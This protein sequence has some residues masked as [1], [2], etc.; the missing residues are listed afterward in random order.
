MYS[1]EQLFVGV[2][3][4]NNRYLAAELRTK[5][6]NKDRHVGSLLEQLRTGRVERGVGNV[7][8]NTLPVDLH[9]PVPDLVVR[10][11]YDRK[12]PHASEEREAGEGEPSSS[13]SSGTE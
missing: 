12:N 3:K 7:V 11:L 9:S 4:E 1:Q 8:V 5:L 10:M 6:V 13:S 2:S